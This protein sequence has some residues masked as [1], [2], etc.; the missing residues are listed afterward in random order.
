MK[1]ATAAMFAALML[2]AC[3]AQMPVFPTPPP[4][5]AETMPLPP[6]SDTPLVWQPGDWTYLDG[7]YHYDP[8]TYVPQAGHGANWAFG[9]WT[10]SNGNYAWIAGQWL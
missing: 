10:G 2:N 8:G 1:I 3:S 7:S 5:P 6:V 4:L 9:H